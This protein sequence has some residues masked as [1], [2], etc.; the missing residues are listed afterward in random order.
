MVATYCLYESGYLKTTILGTH[1][2]NCI[3]ISPGIDTK[4]CKNLGRS[5][6]LECI[7]LYHP[8]TQAPSGFYVNHQG[9]I[10]LLKPKGHILLRKMVTI[11]E[12]L[13]VQRQTP[14]TN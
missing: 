3:N 10:C 13:P 1:A 11:Q 9:E 7:E 8:L 6:K 14:Y 2:R 12:S 5:T 4:Q